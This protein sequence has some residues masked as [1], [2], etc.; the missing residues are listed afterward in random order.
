MKERIKRLYESGKID[1]AGVIH[2]ETLHWIT[3]EDVVDILGY[4]P[5]E[6]EVNET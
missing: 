4:D 6:P 5:Y 1:A 3:R 2:A